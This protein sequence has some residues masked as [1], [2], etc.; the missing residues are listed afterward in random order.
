MRA[1]MCPTHA[2][3]PSGLAARCAS[4]YGRGLA[5]AWAQCPSVAREAQP[6]RRPLRLRR[7]PTPCQRRVTAAAVPP[8]H[9]QQHLSGGVPQLSAQAE[10][11]AE[12]EA[13]AP[14]GDLFKALALGF[15][16]LVSAGALQHDWVGQH[17]ARGAGVRRAPRRRARG[18][19]AVEA[20]PL[21]QG[22]ALQRAHTL[23]PPA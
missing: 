19:H 3:P 6:R 10:D 4:R 20:H 7:C 8:E 16:L 12:H 2:A 11:G 21:P 23:T 17:Q 22:G 5:R 1:S 13:A 9:E 15:T 18:E 14:K